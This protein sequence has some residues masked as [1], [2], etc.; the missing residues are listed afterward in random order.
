MA[1]VEVPPVD[2]SYRWADITDG[3]QSGVLY[4]VTFLSFTYTSLTFLARIFIK[5]RVLGLDD[6]AMLLAQVSLLFLRSS[7]V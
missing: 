7:L 2:R 4:I 1:A 5:W 3:D 6:A